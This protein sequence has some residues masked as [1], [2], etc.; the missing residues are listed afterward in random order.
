METTS[1]D[2]F[3]FDPSKSHK[4]NEVLTLMSQVQKSQKTMGDYLSSQVQHLLERDVQ[5]A[6]AGSCD[7]TGK[8][9][10]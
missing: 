3:I 9:P 7:K 5:G 4:N 1:G 2:H 8:P 6:E 10:F